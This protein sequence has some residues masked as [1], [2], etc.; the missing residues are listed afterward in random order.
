MMI[1]S[2]NG[3][4]LWNVICWTKQYFSYEGI[5]SELDHQVSAMH[6]DNSETNI[7]F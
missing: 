2:E 3:I 5:K 1:F 4:Y 6:N 7:C